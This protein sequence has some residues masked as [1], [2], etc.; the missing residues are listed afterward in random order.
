M[1]P[2]PRW[3][4]FIPSADL[5]LGL[6]HRDLSLLGTGAVDLMAFL[7]VIFPSQTIRRRASGPA[8]MGPSLEWKRSK[9]PLKPS[10]L[11]HV[12]T[13]RCHFAIQRPQWSE[14]PLVKEVR[15]SAS[16]GQFPSA[17]G[18]V[19]TSRSGEHPPFFVVCAKAPNQGFR[20]FVPAIAMPPSP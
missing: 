10:L 15:A 19:E 6:L 12:P 18:C 7:V 1:E 17:S 5:Q 16:R 14:L 20:V 8:R 13:Q 2:V 11:R 9:P 3:E 4:C